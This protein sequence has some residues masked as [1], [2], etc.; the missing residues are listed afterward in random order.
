M[1]AYELYDAAFDSAQ[2]EFAQS[3]VE[4]VKQYADGAF[5]TVVS[6]E[7]AQKIVACRVDFEQN[8]DGSNDFWHMVRKPLEAIE[9]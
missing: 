7:V 6:D 9:L 8:G 5:N 1:N 2:G 3:T 4:Y